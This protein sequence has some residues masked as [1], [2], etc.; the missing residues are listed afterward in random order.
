ME[1]NGPDTRTQEGESSPGQRRTITEGLSASPRLV[2]L[3]AA[4]IAATTDA[5]HD[6]YL[7]EMLSIPAENA[8]DVAIKLQW[9][10]GGNLSE[11]EEH[12][13]FVATYE[14]VGRDLGIAP[15]NIARHADIGEGQSRQSEASP[16]INLDELR[17]LLH[18]MRS[19]DG[20][21]TTWGTMQHLEPLAARL[22][23]IIGQAAP[24]PDADLERLAQ[25]YDLV[26]GAC[27]KN[28]SDDESDRIADEGSAVLFQMFE[29]RASTFAGIRAKMKWLRDDPFTFNGDDLDAA[30]MRSIARDIGLINPEERSA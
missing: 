27:S 26:M 17:S 24:H 16:H 20:S 14:S 29:R 2:S 12:C 23:A 11:S 18:D 30:M 15:G 3:N 6:S 1:H 9:I 28:A 22:E 4:R 25:N 13:P 8:A 19:P 5:E 10:I 7:H 21:T